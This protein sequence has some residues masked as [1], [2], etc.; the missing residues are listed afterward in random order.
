MRNQDRSLTSVI[1]LK[2][3][4]K[5]IINQ[6]PGSQTAIKKIESQLNLSVI[7]EPSIKPKF[8]RNNSIANG[9]T[10]NTSSSTLILGKYNIQAPRLDPS[11]PRRRK[12]MKSKKTFFSNSFVAK[13]NHL[14]AIKKLNEEEERL[15]NASR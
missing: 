3:K 10:Y 11:I 6:H 8:R 12:K 4:L 13:S 2:R 7:E 14:F 9:P 1:T 5:N 15:R